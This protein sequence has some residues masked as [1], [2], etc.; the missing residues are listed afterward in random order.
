VEDSLPYPVSQEEVR[1]LD[2]KLPKDTLFI[3]DQVEIHFIFNKK[4]IGIISADPDIYVVQYIIKPSNEFYDLTVVFQFFK[5]GQIN[6]NSVYVVFQYVDYSLDYQTLY[7][8]SIQETQKKIRFYEPEYL[9]SI[10]ISILNYIIYLF[11]LIIIFV[12]FLIIFRFAGEMKQIITSFIIKRKLINKI[13]NLSGQS[14]FNIKERTYIITH[15]LD[16]YKIKI[17]DEI[18]EK[19]KII[20]FQLTPD[21]AEKEQRIYEESLAEMINFIKQ[22]KRLSH[23]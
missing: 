5:T 15:I 13:V 6:F 1:L 7:V 16:S 11:I 10:N 3:G 14:K 17:P 23:V 18:Q 9:E 22:I 2:I 4:P 21:E 19:L 20:K 8:A 12:V